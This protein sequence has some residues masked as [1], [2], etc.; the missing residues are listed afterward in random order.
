[1]RRR[2]PL[3][4]ALWLAAA[5]ALSLAPRALWSLRSE[6]SRQARILSDYADIG[7]LLLHR[8]PG[9]GSGAVSTFRMP[10]VGFLAAALVSHQRVSWEAFALLAQAAGVLLLCALCALLCAGGSAWGPALAGLALLA[11]PGG[12]GDPDL[13]HCALPVLLV[14]GLL[15]WR[16]RETSWKTTVLLAA[17]IGVSL[18]HRSTLAFFAP[19]LAAGEL[20]GR[21]RPWPRSAWRQALVLALAPYLF[22]APWMGLNWSLHGRFIPFEHG[23]ASSNIV[24]GALGL[25][26]TVEGEAVSLTGGSSAGILGWAARRVL[27]HPG[28]YLGACG[29]RL[30]LLVSWHPALFLFAA[31]G[32]WLGRR[33]RELGHLALLAGYF[34]AVHCLMAV[35][36]LYFQPL[37]PLLLALAVGGGASAGAA[38]LPRMGP[39]WALWAKAVL[40]TALAAALVFAA[41]LSGAMAAYPSAARLSGARLQERYEKELRGSPGHAWLYGQRAAVRLAQG[42]SAGAAADLARAVELAPQERRYQLLLAWAQWLSGKPAALQDWSFASAEVSTAGSTDL[43]ARVLRAYAQ[44][45]AGRLDRAREE[46]RAARMLEESLVVVRGGRSP[47][48]AAV[49]DE[50]RRASGAVIVAAA[51]ELLSRRPIAVRLALLPLL[52]EALPGRP[53]PF[54]GP[55]L[56]DAATADPR[57]AEGALGRLPPFI[58]DGAAR[59]RL[60][61]VFAR[62][63]D[64]AASRRLLA[65]L[66][67][68]HDRDPAVRLA[69]AAAAARAG[70]RGAAL[71]EIELAE[72]FGL[73]REGTLEAALLYAELRAADQARRLYGRLPRLRARDA[74]QAVRLAGLEAVVGDSAAALRRLDSAGVRSA[75]RSLVLAAAGLYIELGRPERAQEL[76]GGLGSSDP[77]VALARARLAAGRGDRAGALRELGLAE[78]ASDDPELLCAAATL[79]AGLEELARARSLVD[80]LSRR[81]ALDGAAALKLAS[82]AAARGWRVEALR[83]LRRAGAAPAPA[84]QVVSAALLYQRL[85]L[86]GE[87][88]RLLDRAAAEEP[89]NARCLSARGVAK[90]LLGRKEEALADLRGAIRSDPRLLESYLSLGSLLGGREAL[91]VYEQGLAVVEPRDANVVSLL[92]RA[93]EE[94]AGRKKDS[95]KA[96]F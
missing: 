72:S 48:S 1:M 70:A 96:G 71:R 15:V 27:A 77:R 19:L 40:G 63:P 53:L 21:R 65:G 83:C 7:E 24:A 52:A 62:L 61:G 73:D 44:A 80:R 93:R 12:L 28:Q 76:L 87:S 82:L 32:W 11:R 91:A 59:R 79:Y 42:D 94:L 67:R 50:L 88:L 30:F 46:L 37:W 95:G 49:L 68:F 3:L 56:E 81:P 41:V 26:E 29:R 58:F 34:A 22:L 25:E 33:R 75:D 45:A 16:A 74:A 2:A 47:R 39:G 5:A 54:A 23:A 35:S 36:P 18:L 64:Q 84:D 10:A 9:A 13:A 55:W 43:R 14:A 4:L 6:P 89:G 85:G 31:A 57:L 69:A 66:A 60:S 20:L 8:V 38:G 86:H 92:R 78:A 90:A 17:G 51:S